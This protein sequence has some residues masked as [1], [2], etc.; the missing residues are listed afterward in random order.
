MRI[1]MPAHAS[2]QPRRNKFNI[3]RCSCKDDD[4]QVDDIFAKVEIVKIVSNMCIGY[5]WTWT[6]RGR[7]YVGV[8]ICKL[9]LLYKGTQVAK[10]D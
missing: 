6:V 1:R 10:I 7:L 2:E 9:V 5:K 4:L 3:H 8:E